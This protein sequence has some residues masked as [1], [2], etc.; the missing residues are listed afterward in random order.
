MVQNPTNDA[1]RSGYDE[2]KTNDDGS[3]DLYFG[4]DMTGGEESNWIETVP[5]RGYYM[6]FRFYSPTEPLFDGTWVLPDV[7]PM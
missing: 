6:M 7:E 2:L 5:G 3:L 4:P 1:A